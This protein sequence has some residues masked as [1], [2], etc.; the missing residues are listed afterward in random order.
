MRSCKRREVASDQAGIHTPDAYIGML[1]KRTQERRI[2]ARA[3]NDDNADD[4]RCC[5]Y[6]FWRTVLTRSR[7]FV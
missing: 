7:L 1:E 5:S 3:R 2:H 4:G 6:S